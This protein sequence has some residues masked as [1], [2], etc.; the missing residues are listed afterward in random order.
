MPVETQLLQRVDALVSKGQALFQYHPD[1]RFKSQRL[2]IRHGAYTS[3]R[4]QC[5]ALVTDLLGET[6]SY[7]QEFHATVPSATRGGVVPLAD[8]NG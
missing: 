7:A 5:L 8:T 2:P 1:D 6:H 4:A 3:W